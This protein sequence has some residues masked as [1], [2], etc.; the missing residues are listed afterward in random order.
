FPCNEGT[1]HND[2]GRMTIQENCV[3]SKNGLRS[4]QFLI[5]CRT[6]TSSSPADG[7]R[8]SFPRAIRDVS[9]TLRTSEEG[10]LRC[11]VLVER[12]HGSAIFD[13]GASRNGCIVVC[14]DGWGP[15]SK[16]ESCAA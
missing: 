16:H 2:C 14:W 15:R 9:E 12:C 7:R 4:H 13:T 10:S 8:H 5:L 1:I 3:N 6:D 11:G